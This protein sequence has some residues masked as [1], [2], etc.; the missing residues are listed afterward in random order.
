MLTTTPADVPVLAPA[1]VLATGAVVGSGAV[2][3]TGGVVAAAP[4]AAANMATSARPAIP[5]GRR[6]D[7]IDMDGS[8][9]QWEVS[10]NPTSHGSNWIPSL[11]SMPSRRLDEDA[12]QPH[13]TEKGATR[14]EWAISLAIDGNNSCCH[15]RGHAA[16]HVLAGGRS[17]PWRRCSM[18]QPDEAR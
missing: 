6:R 8:P 2:V 9:K 13:R 17:A 5:A 10:T 15:H 16:G 12:T 18:S 11:D 14:V 1:P 4:Q 7:E 3:A